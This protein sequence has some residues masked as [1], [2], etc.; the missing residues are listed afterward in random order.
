LIG[1]SAKLDNITKPAKAFMRA[2]FAA[3]TIFT[4]AAFVSGHLR[5]F[6]PQSGFTHK[7]LAGSKSAAFIRRDVISSVPG[8]RGEW[9]SYTPGLFHSDIGSTHSTFAMAEVKNS[10][11]VSF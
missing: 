2:C 1:W 8:T 10:Y 4:S 9:M 11:N 7:C 5:V 3:S 6:K